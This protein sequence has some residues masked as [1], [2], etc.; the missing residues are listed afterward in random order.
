MKNWHVY[1]FLLIVGAAFL[2]GC[3]STATTETPPPA[4][5]PQ[6]APPPP[7]PPPPPPE[8]A[9]PTQTA[10]D[11]LDAAIARAEQER[12]QAADFGASA[13]FPGDWESAET[14]YG[15]ISVDRTSPQGVAEAERLYNEAADRY[16]EIFRRAVALYAGDMEE[17]L[18]KARSEA[19]AA[20]IAEL[21]PEYLDTADRA[22]GAARDLFGAEDYYKAAES[23]REALDR[24]HVLTTG[25]EA[26]KIRE[27][28]V[29][30]DFT[31][32]DA[33]NFN[34]GDESLIA[35]ADIYEGGGALTDALS[36]AAESK[37]RYDA[38]L[39]TGWAAY[40]AQLRALASK[41]RQNALSAKADVAVKEDFT[42]IEGVFTQAESSYRSQV[43]ENAVNLY[44][45]SEAGFVA[46]AQ[47]AE[48]KRRLAQAAIDAAEK[49][50]E[51]SET[52]VR[53]AEGILEG[54]RE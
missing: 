37:L 28:V 45:R 22:A 39:K 24:Y 25:A 7:P 15:A 52:T 12:K 8:P 18:L 9:R 46:L 40:A 41:E 38:A 43:Y 30:L 50:L 4:P 20:G 34:Q 5:P 1:V 6:E 17:E 53:N 33:D 3:G 27:E 16:N 36:A 2:G 48:E 44:V 26:Y 21:A 49:K 47:A 54:D 19:I 51:E 14:G 10:L 35:A 11:A 29:R 31:G 13:Y 32:F 42:V 23:G